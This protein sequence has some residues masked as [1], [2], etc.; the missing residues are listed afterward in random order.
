V[1]PHEHQWIDISWLGRDYASRLCVNCNQEERRF[2]P[3]LAL[4]DSSLADAEWEMV[5]QGGGAI[6]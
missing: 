6:S 3:A 5:R 4:A 2:L 1:T